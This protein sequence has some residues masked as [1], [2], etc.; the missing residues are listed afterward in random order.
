MLAERKVFI[1][2]AE[3]R[4]HLDLVY[5]NAAG[6]LKDQARKAQEVDIRRIEGLAKNA[7]N[8][9]RNE[10]KHYQILRDMLDALGQDNELFHSMLTKF[11]AAY[12][13]DR[14]KDREEMDRIKAD[15]MEEVLRR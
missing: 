6:S 2:S 9:N 7:A 5:A 8:Q 4:A 13:M 1:A 3:D 14:K 15:L 11:M 10:Q 12:E